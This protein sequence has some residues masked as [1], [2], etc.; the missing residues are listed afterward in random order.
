M[1]ADGRDGS[2]MD[3]AADGRDGSRM[4]DLEN[5]TLGVTA[6]KPKENGSFNLM[7]EIVFSV[8]LLT[9]LV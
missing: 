3:D 9:I 5:D 2:R 4:D 1:A 7:S 6:S 8:L